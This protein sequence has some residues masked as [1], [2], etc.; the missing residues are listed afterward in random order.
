MARSNKFSML[1]NVHYNEILRD[2][3][4]VIFVPKFTQKIDNLNSQDCLNHLLNYWD[5]TYHVDVS[6]PTIL[7]V[8]YN[9]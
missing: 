4:F 5:T 1:T 3:N 8:P 9:S 2:A 7:V 6:T